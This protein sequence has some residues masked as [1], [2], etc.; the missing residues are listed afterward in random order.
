MTPTDLASPPRVL[1]VVPRSD[2][3]IPLEAYLKEQGFEVLRAH[4]GAAGYDVL[5]REPVDVLICLL[6][7]PRIDG[8][9]LIQ[10]AR[11]GIK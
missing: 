9:R 5:D 10:L 11:P 2:G 3:V 8:L 6:R 1:L 7:N 4:E